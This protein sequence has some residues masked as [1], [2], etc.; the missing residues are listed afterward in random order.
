[1]VEVIQCNDIADII[2][3]DKYRGTGETSRWETFAWVADAVA[4]VDASSTRWASSFRDVLDRGVFVPGGRIL[5]GA[6]T[7][8]RVTLF[9][10]FVMDHIPDDV[11]G[12]FDAVRKAALTMQQGGGIGCDFSSLR[13]KGAHVRGIGADAS[14]PVSFMSVWDTMCETIVSAGARRG[15]M[16]A[17]LRCDHP[18]IEAFIEAKRGGGA[19]KNFNLSVLVTDDFMQ[20][21]DNDR[22]WPLRWNGEIVGHKSA[23]SIWDKIMRANY[24]SAEPGVVFIDRVNREN[25]LSYCE[26]I[27]ATNPCGEQPLP[28]NGACLLGSINLAALVR[29]PFERDAWLDETE[30]ERVV[31]VAVR[32]L[33]NVIDASTLPLP[34]QAK[35]ALAKRRMGLGVTGLANALSMVGLRYGTDQSARQAGAWFKLLREA[36]YRASVALAK[37]RGPF[38]LFDREAFLAAPGAL[39]LPADI[40][41]GISRHGFRNGVLTSIAP[42]GTT[43]LFAGN[44]SSGIEPVFDYEFQRR[45]RGAD[46]RVR[47]IRVEDYAVRLWRQLHGKEKALPRS[48]VRTGELVPEAHLRVVAAV[49]PDVDA[50]ISKT[51]NCAREIPFGAFESIYR[52][53]YALGLKGCT[54]YRPNAITG[55]VLIEAD[56][57]SDREGERAAHSVRVEAGRPQTKTAELVDAS[58]ASPEGRPRRVVGGVP[59]SGQE[60]HGE[61]RRA[62][63]GCG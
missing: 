13:P 1:M 25:N 46:G 54:T 39:R 28:F 2:W 16:M 7:G 57:G 15:A 45:M 24:E 38:P 21:L 3:R 20:A 12:I 22:P 55:A 27:H 53:A 9:N 17:T 36:A 41:D 10:C 59:V 37:E 29:K 8:R 49:Q 44:V 33:D 11:S 5:S 43:S 40:R 23:R 52:R 32:F 62:C 63:S 31:S 4:A 14:G 18:D 35:E 42:T 47:T 26:V 50:G 51:I 34:E 30:L 61:T 19:F 6:G 58:G 60:A 48:M 56:A